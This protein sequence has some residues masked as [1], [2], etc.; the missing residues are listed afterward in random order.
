M[1]HSCPA[2]A[3][4]GL[5]SRTAS[6]ESARAPSPRS[7]LAKPK[8]PPPGVI[9]SN[10][11]AALNMRPTTAPGPRRARKL[12][13]AGGSRVDLPL[14]GAVGEELLQRESS[15]LLSATVGGARDAASLRLAARRET[16]LPEEALED[17]VT[18]SGDLM[19]GL[20]A[21]GIMD[22]APDAFEALASAEEQAE[23]DL[24]VVEGRGAAR[25]RVELLQRLKD[26]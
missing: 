9:R 23:A 10:F 12:A 26:L 16:V 14:R 2:Q 1:N 15:P 18:K 8:L 17:L 11:G 19:D 21:T 4:A 5:S 25:L 3:A 7:S 20:V 24:D 22:T 6:I 13:P